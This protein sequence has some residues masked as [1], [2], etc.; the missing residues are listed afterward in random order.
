MKKHSFFRAIV[1]ALIL[2]LSGF[3]N[4]SLIEFEDFSNNFNIDNYEEDGFTIKPT[5]DGLG[6]L[7]AGYLENYWNGNGSG[8]LITWTNVGSESG[9]EIS[10]LNGDL[11]SLLGF[12]FGNA[13]TSGDNFVSYVTLTGLLSNGSTITTN[14]YTA[15]TTT[16][17]DDWLNLTSVKF[18]ANGS[19]NRAYWDNIVVN[20]VSVPEP[21][22]LAI[23]VIGVIGLSSRRLKK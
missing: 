10:M 2:A 19:D 4:A 21:S 9:F 17:S 16:L 12:E 20:S 18:I 6:I 15:G 14:F 1:T 3:A 13:Y 23:F 5:N 7:E 8:R 22:T 11:F